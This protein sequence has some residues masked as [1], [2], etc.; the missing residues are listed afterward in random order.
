MMQHNVATGK[1]K[2]KN[3]YNY[4][5]ISTGKVFIYMYRMSE[6]NTPSPR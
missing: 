5:T 4:L 3:V 1:E 2:E 6:I